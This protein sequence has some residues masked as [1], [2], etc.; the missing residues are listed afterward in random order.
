MPTGLSLASVPPPLQLVF[1]SQLINTLISL[2]VIVS[3]SLRYD[4]GEVHC[5]HAVCRQDMFGST[6]YRQMH[7]VWARGHYRKT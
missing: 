6:F 1:S 3:P 5:G 2:H 7:N 4:D